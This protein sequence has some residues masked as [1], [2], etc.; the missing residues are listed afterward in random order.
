MS[1]STESGRPEG[2]PLVE[3]LLVPKGAG[4]GFFPGVGGTL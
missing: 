4:V 2:A 1:F 3:V